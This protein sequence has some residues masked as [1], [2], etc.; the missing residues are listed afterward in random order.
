M[1][2][3]RSHRVAGQGMNCIGDGWRQGTLPF[4]SRPIS[5]R[6]GPLEAHGVQP[7]AG[8]IRIDVDHDE[9]RAAEGPIAPRRAGV[10]DPR[11]RT[12]VDAPPVGMPVDHD[13]GLGIALAQP[14]V[15]AFHPRDLMPM[16]YRD[17]AARQREHGFHGSCS[18]CRCPHGSH[19]EATSLLPRTAITCRSGRAS[20]SSTA[21]LPMSPAWTANRHR[22]TTFT[23]RGSR[24]PW[25]SETIATRNRGPG[26]AAPSTW[27]TG[28]MRIPAHSV[29]NRIGR[30][31][32]NPIGWFSENALNRHRYR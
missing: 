16:D 14:S 3:E 1:R 18:S 12:A 9:R 17:P 25:V 30:M 13:A 21:P 2:G 10:D 22:S 11:A 20:V 23:I 19:F 26:L 31:Q 32:C 15:P 27:T 5:A 29:P 28:V 6:C 8:G 24:W 4:S 7:P